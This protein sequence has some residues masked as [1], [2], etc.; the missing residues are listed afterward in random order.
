MP[1][2]APPSNPTDFRYNVTFSVFAV[3]PLNHPNL[4]A[5]NGN[6]SSPF[7]GQSTTLQGGFGTAGGAVTYNRKITMQLQLTF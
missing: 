7:F 3:N 1:V 5:P 2:Q 6:F 4:A